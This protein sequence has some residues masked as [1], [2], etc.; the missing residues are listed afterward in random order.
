MFRKDVYT[1][2][3]KTGKAQQVATVPWI[4]TDFTSLASS[5]S[6]NLG[7]PWYD[8]FGN[9]FVLRKAGSAIAIGNVLGIDA[10]LSATVQASSTL[11]VVNTNATLT[12]NAEKGSFFIDDNIG[13][14]GTTKTDVLKLIKANT[15][16]ANSNVTVS[17]NNPAFA[18]NQPDP[19]AYITA[20]ANTDVGRICRPHQVIP[21]PTARAATSGVIGIAVQAITSATFGFT[22]TRGIALVSAKGDVVAWAVNGPVVADGVAAGFAKGAATWQLTAVGPVIGESLSISVAASATLA[23]GVVVLGLEN[24]S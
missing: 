20:P 15:G 21:M 13:N 5:V 23:L 6:F 17:Q 19:D 2:F 4:S 14:A 7:Q 8:D 1:H 22:Q 3:T 12:A 9:V 10:P 24:M 18:N 16:G 11:Q